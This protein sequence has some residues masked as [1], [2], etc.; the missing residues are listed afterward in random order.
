[1]NTVDEENSTL[2]PTNINLGSTDGEEPAVAMA[3]DELWRKQRGLGGD[4]RK[5]RDQK[6]TASSAVHLGS[7]EDTT[8]IGEWA[9]SGKRKSRD[10][11]FSQARNIMPSATTA[12]LRPATSSFPG[13]AAMHTAATGAGPGKYTLTTAQVDV[14]EDSIRAKHGMAPRTNAHHPRDEIGR[15]IRDAI[16]S[17]YPRQWF[18]IR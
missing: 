13:L 1:M 15:S 8:S 9:E 3:F 2:L 7:T 5:D 6:D 4:G 11:H 18:I 12:R 10:T 16:W 14:L 17:R